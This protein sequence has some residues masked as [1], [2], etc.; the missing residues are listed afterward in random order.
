MNDINSAM[1]DGLTACTAGLQFGM[2]DFVETLPTVVIC[3]QP[4]YMCMCVPLLS[5]TIV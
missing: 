2:T 5:Y 1:D 4:T 3:L